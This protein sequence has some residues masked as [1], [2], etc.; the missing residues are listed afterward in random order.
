MEKNECGVHSCQVEIGRNRIFVNVAKEYGETHDDIYQMY[1]RK[2][3][4]I[5]T[6][7]GRTQNVSFPVRWEWDDGKK[8]K[9]WF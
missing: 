5:E 3:M 4:D 6:T 1:S 8:G 2:R 9:K 7:E